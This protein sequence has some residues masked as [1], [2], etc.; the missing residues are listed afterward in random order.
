MQSIEVKI[1][2][3]LV[4]RCAERATIANISTKEWIEAS[5]QAA[6]EALDPSG[7]VER[8]RTA[9]RELRD[10]T[11]ATAP[12]ASCGEPLGCI[13]C[14]FVANADAALSGEP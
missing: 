12:H 2:R 4:M 1:E 5:I 10:W 14:G 3:A 8:L 7:E 6:I 9:L 13:T 11:Q